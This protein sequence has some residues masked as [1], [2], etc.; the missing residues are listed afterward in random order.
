L[1]KGEVTLIQ[2]MLQNF[3]DNAW[4]YTSKT[5]LARIEFGKD[6]SQGENIFFVRDSGSGFDMKY[7]DK[8]FGAFQR[9]CGT[10]EFEGT[11]I[12]LATVQRIVMRHGGRIWAEA[13]PNKGASFCFELPSVITNPL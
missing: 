3:L 10:D 8:L 11:G 7:I 1:I 13:K 4:K 6:K 9:L 2:F 5:K 12:G